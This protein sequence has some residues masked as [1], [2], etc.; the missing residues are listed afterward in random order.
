MAAAWDKVQ[1]PALFARSVAAYQMLPDGLVGIFALVM[2]MLEMVAG[3]ALIATRWS[4]EAALLVLGMLGMFLVALVQA[5]ARGLEISCGCFGDAVE[6]GGDSLAQAIVRDLVMLA[7]T[8]WLVLRPNNW[9]LGGFRAGARTALVAFCLVLAAGCG[10]GDGDAAPPAGQAPVVVEKIVPDR[11]PC[12]GVTPETWTTNFTAALSLARA[13]RQPL[14]VVASSKTCEHCR[15]MRAFV[16]DQPTFRN[17]VEGTGIYLVKA[18]FDETNSCPEQAQAIGFVTNSPPAGKI[19]G[20]P[21][22]GVYWPR[23]TNEE[24]R[25][26]FTGSRGYMPGKA[27]HRS[28]SGAFAGA[29]EAVLG[30]YLLRLD[31]PP[32]PERVLDKAVKR[33]AVAQEGAGVVSMRPETGILRDDGVPVTLSAR[34]ASGHRF[35]GWRRPDGKIQAGEKLLLNYFQDA[36]TYTAVF[37]PGGR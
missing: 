11:S 1:D 15:R 2:P 6:S 37:E 22:F 35:R 4:R 26:Y 25:T 32:T 19:H 14:L 33:I 24:L 5:K 27:N 30:D 10:R 23:G 7:P 13:R 21:F 28:L 12:D 18:S 8:I 16:L 29:M 20:W 34:S 9:L 31:D 3:V 17:W 36:G